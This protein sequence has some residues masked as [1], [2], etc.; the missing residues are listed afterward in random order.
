MGGI[1]VADLTSVSG[2]KLWRSICYIT[3][4][5]F[6]LQLMMV[7]QVPVQPLSKLAQN[8]RV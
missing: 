2:K 6:V 4:C 8:V 3:F 5:V 1:F 7:N